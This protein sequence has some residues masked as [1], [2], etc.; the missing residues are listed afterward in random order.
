MQPYTPRP[1]PVS[2][3]CRVRQGFLHLVKNFLYAGATKGKENR[4]Q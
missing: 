3:P 2:K 1:D 4:T